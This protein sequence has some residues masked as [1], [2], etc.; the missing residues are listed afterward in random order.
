MRR[1][2]V[3]LSVLLALILAI[4][5]ARSE[6]PSP[7]PAGAPASQFSAIRAVDQLRQVLGGNIPHPVG[8]PA[9]DAVRDRIVARFH[10]LGYDT[11]LQQRFACNPDLECANVSNIIAGL[12]GQ[13]T[14][15]AIV[16]ACHY[17]SVGAGPGA[18]DDGVGVATM[19]E[20]ARA[21]R[22]EHFRNPI[23]I[24][25]TDAEEAG[26]IGAEGF[27]ADDTASQPI[28]A[29]IN[30]EDRGTSGTSYL[31]ETSR[32]NRWLIDLADDALARPA[33]SSLFYSIYE[34][35]PNDTDL[36]VFKRAGKAGINF[37]A[38]G[39]VGYYH[40]PLD[41]LEHVTPS[42]VQHHGE[43]V[44][45]MVRALGNADLRQRSDD[46]ATYFDLLS[47]RLFWWPEPWTMP[48][49]L[50]V[51]ALLLVAAALRVR[52]QETRVRHIA[53]GLLSFFLS[54]ILAFI[55][56]FGTAW[57]ASLRSGGL[58]WVAYPLPVLVA[59]WLVGLGTAILVASLFKHGAGFEGLFLGHGLGWIILALIVAT[60]LSGGSYL[61]LLPGAAFALCAIA[62]ATFELSERVTVM[63]CAA[64]AAALFFILAITLYP[65]LG[66]GALAGV[67]AI[68][69]LVATTFTP[70]FA[71]RPRTQVAIFGTAALFVIVALFMPPYDRA[72]PRRANVEYVGFGDH[73]YWTSSIELPGVRGSFRSLYDWYDEDIVDFVADA[74]NLP[75]PPP[76]VQVVSDARG[77]K[78][79]L[80]L[81]VRSV[82]N[83][84]RIALTFRTAATVDSIRVNGIAP[85]AGRTSNYL[86]A[87]WHRVTV[88]A[89]SARIEITMRGTRPIDTVVTDYS[90]GLPAEGAAV[91]RARA[92]ADAVASYEGDVA[93][94][95]RRG[96]L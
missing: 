46:N 90:W 65:A 80:T 59:M 72:H 21:I 55:M 75:L 78:R 86:G 35:M 15:D 16:L 9:H 93:V 13:P 7:Q 91:A 50:F 41:N 1:D 31:F 18:S 58:K 87:Q 79:V 70:L 24:L 29:V 25:I 49:A 68:V 53:A 36:T 62:R 67:A 2:A 56:G 14:A 92:A 81:D 34:L 69:A 33:A 74:P 32:L 47:F 63:I 37:A 88:Y 77:G 76:V 23:L 38:I 42:T 83:A 51:L 96:K 45:A 27:V 22:T 30:V 64:L 95:V 43:N 26:L 28:A 66:R 11:R 8:T 44:L 57:I 71:G 3:L 60:A 73:A 61:F 12:P 17:D 54:I 94:E 19:L 84:P 10:A 52:E 48:M 89:P 39:N 5:I 40:T 85:P 20:V 4:T 82:R 6:G